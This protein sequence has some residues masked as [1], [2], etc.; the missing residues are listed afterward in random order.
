MCQS[1][2]YI[3]NGHEIKTEFS[4]SKALLPVRTKQHIDEL[5]PWGRRKNQL[6]KLP[7]GGW[8]HLDAIKAG[9]WDMYI[10]KSVQIHLSSFMEKDIFDAP[11]WYPLVRSQWIQ[12]LIAREGNEMRVYI[13]TITPQDP[14]II[15][16]RWPRILFS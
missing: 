5:V 1:V 11:R 3:H 16:T 13:V 15:H 10:P 4:N 8:A 2:I 12:G 14:Q 9:Q 6:G 7:L